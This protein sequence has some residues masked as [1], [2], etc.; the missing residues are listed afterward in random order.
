M[1][2]ANELST[3]GH[4]LRDT[5]KAAILIFM[6]TN[7]KGHMSQI[8]T[9]EGKTT[10]ISVVAALKVMQGYKTH[11]I[12]SNNVLAADGVKDKKLFYDLLN[13]TTTDN[14]PDDKYTDGP[15]ACYNKDIVYG[16][17]TSF[18]F[19]WL[20]DSFEQLQTLGGIDF[21]N[22]WVML[23]EIDSL[24]I[25]QG[26]NI[27][28]LSGPF[29]G[30]ESLRYVYINIWIAL[31]KTVEQ[32]TQQI[33]T[34]LKA[35]ADKLAQDFET[36][37][38]E[39]QIEYEKYE[40]SLRESF[41]DEIKKQIKNQK[42]HLINK[43]ILAQHLHQYAEDSIERWIEHA[44]IAKYK[45][46]ENVEYKISKDKDRENI[47]TP[48]DNQNTG[49]SMKNTI[50]SN[51]LHQFLQIK[52]NLCLTYESLTSCYVSNLDYIKKYGSK[53]SGVT[54]TLGSRSERNLLG[55]VFNLEFSVIPPFKPKKFKKFPGK[56]S[57]DDKFVNDVAI[58]ALGELARTQIK[59]EYVEEK[60]QSA[61]NKPR[62]VLI[63]CAS[64]LDVEII[65]QEVD[66]EAK[67]AG[68]TPKIRQYR[69]EIDAH[70][71][72]SILDVC[73][74]V[75]ATNL[76]GRGT[77]FKTSARL[78]GNCGLHV[79]LAFLPCN[80]RVE[81]QGFGRTGRQGNNGTG[82]IITKISELEALGI[83]VSD[84]QN[85]EFKEVITRRDKLETMRVND[86]A[87]NKITELEFK[88]QLFNKFSSLYGSLKKRSKTG[89]N[90]IKWIYVLRDLKEKWAFWLEKQTYTA[91][92]IKK[93]IDNQKSWF[94]KNED[95]FVKA[96]E[97]EYY[98]FLKEAKSI[99]N[100]TISHNPFYS[101]CLSER[102]LENSIDKSDR[103]KAKSE[104]E[105]AL[106]ISNSSELLY[107]AY[108]KLFEI[109]IE[110][111]GQVL[112]RYQ[113]AVANIFFFPLEKNCP[114]Y[115]RH[116][117]EHLEKAAKA[118]TIEHDYLEELIG[119]KN[120]N[121]TQQEESVLASIIIS[122]KGEPDNNQQT[123]CTSNT[124]LFLKHLQARLVCLAVYKENI[125]SLIKQIKGENKLENLEPQFVIGVNDGAIIDCK[126]PRYLSKLDSHNELKKHITERSV[127]E[128]EYVGMSSIYQ[129]RKIH[130]V[131]KEVI[132]RAQI[133]IGGAFALLA[134]AAV[135]PVL[136]PVNGQLA[137]AMMS[138]GITDIIIA[139]IQQGQSAFN[140]KDYVKGKVISYGIS[141]VTMGIDALMSS[142]KILNKAMNA[143][144]SLAAKLRAVKGPFAGICKFLAN[145]LET[146]AKYLELMIEKIEFARKTAAEQAKYL[147][148]LKDANQLQKFQQLQKLIK[149][150]DVVMTH[151]QKIPQIA[152]QSAIGAIKG[153]VISV[154]IEKIVTA[155]LNNMMTGLQ[156]IIKEKVRNAVS[157]K[158][159]GYYRKGTFNNLTDSEINQIIK[160]LFNTSLEEDIKDVSKQI[161]L[162]ILRHSSNWKMQLATLAF[163]SIL[164]GIDI[165]TCTNAA[166]NKFIDNLPKKQITN[167]DN[168]KSKLTEII[169]T[170]ISEAVSGII[171]SQIVAI[172]GEIVVTLP[173]AL[174]RGYKKH[175]EK[176]ADEKAITD[177]RQ[178]LNQIDSADDIA[179]AENTK[180]VH[181][182]VSETLGLDNNKGSKQLTDATNL[183]ASKDGASI[184]DTKQLFIQNG[185]EVT[186]CGIEDAQSQ[187]VKQGSDRGVICLSNDQGLGHVKAVTMEGNCLMI[188]EKGQKIPLD[189][190]KQ[191]H[192]YS[193]AECIIPK[194]V[195]SS[196]LEDIQ[197]KCNLNRI[198]RATHSINYV[199]QDDKMKF[200]RRPHIIIDST[201]PNDIEIMNGNVS[202]HMQINGVEGRII[203]GNGKAHSRHSHVGK[204][205]GKTSFKDKGIQDYVYSQAKNCNTKK[206]TTIITGNDK[207]KRVTT[208][209]VNK[210]EGY[211]WTGNK[212]KCKNRNFQYVKLVEYKGKD[213]KWGLQTMYP[214]DK[215]QDW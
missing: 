81:D 184:G 76:A 24:L 168:D 158:I 135:Y 84:N 140:E 120:I 164:T 174:Y 2:R 5:Q 132:S 39:K 203:A 151:G 48:V 12:T 26:G 167:N 57:A 141:V 197:H 20:R 147:C 46:K 70:I 13:I 35:K 210:Y 162:G 41:L 122:K 195:N 77:D 149:F 112:K 207:E 38:D 49:V 6:Q 47:I 156:P 170:Q 4:R 196:T 206:T 40:D 23:D 157:I 61:I 127:D 155:S 129:L 45:Y 183:A 14:N 99:I 44:F 104:I 72:E 214:C 204:V 101:I 80:K 75:I 143:C 138:E 60:Q 208:A 50:L 189:Q 68:L 27:A 78:E 73:D 34:Q 97:Q 62:A 171:Y 144:R 130:D 88:G 15:K 63:V 177:I 199:G 179:K 95:Y 163:E 65:A 59:H 173:K 209:K 18:Q 134:S 160:Q 28:K 105:H 152:V 193:K 201:D 194:N 87:D 42:D 212:R 114:D 142:T 37:E 110:N 55:S 107:S 36:H 154:A 153:V 124:N 169:I 11:I 66:K 148:Q 126:V 187:F 128:L 103:E 145:R 91:E 182:A 102:Y 9:G 3:R 159:K 89:T 172:T 191:K 192:G 10:I 29:P 96:V 64:I 121:D 31:A 200:G 117:V 125:A 93:I 198:I 67:A 71:T 211:D 123:N 113:K 115:K 136:L 69:D 119:G 106:K 150:S 165:A 22:I 92:N 100:G 94:T 109:A 83:A 32:V 7:T 116:A 21:N 133:Q 175:Q 19:D 186:S 166:C 85:I 205:E 202:V 58:A 74:I 54:G 137:G 30:M 190:Y 53:L 56:I 43:T 213:G 98:K 90:A 188:S 79:I 139:L 118:L 161:G 181:D 82:Q 146:L 185:I 51:G 16:S 52:H 8:N 86:I 108:I 215:P 1:D 131:H 178:K 111:G 17:I 25:D 176:K 180:C 33:L